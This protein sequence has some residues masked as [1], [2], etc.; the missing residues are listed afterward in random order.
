[1]ARGSRQPAWRLHRITVSV[2]LDEPGRWLAEAAVLGQGG[3]RFA[4][5]TAQ[6]GSHR[7]GTSLQIELP[8]VDGWSVLRLTRTGLRPAE[9]DAPSLPL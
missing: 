3:D 8:V 2:L 7:Q 6:R 4:P 9:T 5:V 1:M